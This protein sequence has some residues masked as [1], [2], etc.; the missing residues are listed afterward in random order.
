MPSNEACP[1]EI[2]PAPRF[3]PVEYPDPPG[4][5]PEA[6]YLCP[7][8]SLLRKLRTGA[9]MALVGLA[10]A[11]SV[12]LAFAPRPAADN[13]GPDEAAAPA[14]S[15]SVPVEAAAPAPAVAGKP[16]LAPK[17]EIPAAAARAQV[18]CDDFLASFLAAQCRQVVGRAGKTRSARTARARAH[19]LA[20]VAIGRAEP[21]SDPPGKAAAASAPSVGA[22]TIIAA[23]TAGA[24]KAVATEAAASDAASPAKPKPPVR[25]V[26]K[27]RRPSVAAHLDDATAMAR[28]GNGG[29][30]WGGNWGGGPRGG[31]RF[32]AADVTHSW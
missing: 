18:N 16:D 2:S 13:G 32:G 4:F 27:E 30:Y 20:T 10:T 28:G 6:G 31:V 17:R 7:S 14:L 3:Y 25:T 11:A 12:T 8:P 5:H 19:R 26:H 21:E 1:D 23:D 29:G 22:T 15:A 9:V 24:P